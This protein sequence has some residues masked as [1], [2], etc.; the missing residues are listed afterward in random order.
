VAN[1]LFDRSVLIN[2]KKALIF[3][4]IISW[5]TITGGLL[6]LLSNKPKPL[7]HFKSDN[8]AIEFDYSDSWKVTVEGDFTD[9]YSDKYITM[10][11]KTQPLSIMI[12]VK[13]NIAPV[14][15]SSVRPVCEDY[16]D[17][18][19]TISTISYKYDVVDFNKLNS[20]IPLYISKNGG[21]LESSD[22]EGNAQLQA[23]TLKAK[24][25][26]YIYT[27]INGKLTNQIPLNS[28]VTLEISYQ[29]DGNFSKERLLIITQGIE[30]TVN[31]IGGQ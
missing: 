13:K 12:R 14:V 20:K 31:S 2:M 17:C 15:S 26:Y 7:S 18:Q 28:G 23:D 25:S 8:V 3:I 29:I 19:F 30:S 22:T 10:D 4:I 9:N 1:K 21:I 11:Y 5:L 24:N 16:N 6:V 27:L